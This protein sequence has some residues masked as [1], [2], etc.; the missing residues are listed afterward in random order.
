MHLRY[1]NTA[2]LV[3]VAVL[4]LSGVYGIFFTLNGWMFEVHRIAAWALVALIPWKLGISW[5]SLKRG[6]RP[7]FDRGVMIAVS[8]G[9]GLA[10]LAVLA[11]G[12]LWAWRVGPQVLWLEQTTISWHWVIAL[13]LVPP[14]ALHAWRRWPKPRTAD[15]TARRSALR[16][17]SIVGISLVGW[18]AAEWIAQARATLDAPRGDTG[19]RGSGFFSG[20]AFPVTGEWAEPIDPASW[21]LSV[22]GA[23]AASRALSYGEVLA[24]PARDIT[25]TI[26][27][28]TG[29]Y[30]LQG[31][32]GISLTDLVA[33]LGPQ[34]GAAYVRLKSAT[35]YAATFG[36][37]EAREILLATHVG[38]SPLDHLHGFPMRAVVPSRR[39]WYWV[40]WLADV[41]VLVSPHF[42][43][44][45]IF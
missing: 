17:L 25:A 28:T 26:D 8:V 3:V 43:L 15:F 20:N 16:T 21:R 24:L 37:D 33:R 40:K 23:L 41:E 42:D 29:W 5:R 10:T 4:T 2:I 32:R 45:G 14:F 7:R 6:L 12:F 9:L 30:S 36:L 38:A 35:G 44:P 27:C 11:L 31:W 22:H 13:G 19:S 39:G 34:A 1:T 18:G